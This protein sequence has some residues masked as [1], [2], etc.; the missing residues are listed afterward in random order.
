MVDVA[1][2]RGIKIPDVGYKLKVHLIDLV[3][4]GYH[5]IL[6]S[7]IATEMEKRKTQMQESGRIEILDGKTY[8]RQD[9]VAFLLSRSI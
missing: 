8:F 1:D 6:F 9:D 2:C 4:N 5:S 7:A 3:V